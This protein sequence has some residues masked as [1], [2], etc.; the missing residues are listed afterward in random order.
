MNDP[1]TPNPQV[2]K[3]AESKPPVEAN[4]IKPS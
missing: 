2:Q 3:T 4:P 1:E